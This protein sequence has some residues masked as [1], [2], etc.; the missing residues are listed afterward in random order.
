M[1]ETTNTLGIKYAAN[2]QNDINLS[3]AMF[4]IRRLQSEV[5]G[6]RA[7]A[8]CLKRAFGG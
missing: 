4:R 5:S 7:A 6:K 1:P 2:W 3:Q 8:E